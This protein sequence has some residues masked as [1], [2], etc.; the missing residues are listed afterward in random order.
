MQTAAEIGLIGLA[1][2]GE[3]LSLNLAN[4]GFAVSVFN[5][6]TAR[7]DAFIRGRARGT[8]ISGYPTLA[9]FI[10][11]LAPPRKIMLMLKAG[12]VV[13]EVIEQLLPY[14]EAGDILIDGG[15]SHYRDTKR[16]VVMLKGQGLHF[17]GCGVSGGEEGALHGP[18][19][20]PG[21]S[22]E[23]WPL[24]EPLL[25]PIAARLSDGSSCCSWLGPGG[26]GHFVKMVHNGI[27][28]GDMQ[29]IAE[30]YHLITELLGL[31]HRQIGEIFARWNSG[32]L[33]SYLI[34]ITAE[35]LSFQ[36]EDGSP[37]LEAILDAA[38]Q[39][40]TGKWTVDA[41]L[42]L[43]IPLSLISESVFA[44]CLSASKEQRL[45]AA[46]VFPGPGG[47]WSGDPRA[48]LRDLEAALYMAKLISYGQ[49]FQL[50]ATASRDFSWNL[51]LGEVARI[52]RGGCII[53]SAFL[54][55][56]SQAYAQCPE[57]DQLLL[58]PHF[59]TTLNQAQAALRRVITA[60]VTAGI[61]APCL[62]SSL[63]YFDGLR[64]SRLPANLIQA[65]RDYF[66]AHTYERTDQP[67]GRF[68]HTNWTGQGGET[69]SG[70]S[71]R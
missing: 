30:S 2:M 4:H 16:R 34:E 50:L 8:T 54:E 20:M 14:L 27:E 52:W 44:R 36:D 33:N 51:D 12:P 40:G 67:R 19:L 45:A 66:G 23:A 18:S 49:G 62:C 53:R 13:D 41:A 29:L 22:K 43:G 69:T 11:S 32:R 63:Q 68:F 9:A 47:S 39:K 28:Y 64:S 17:V 24:L 42:D 3:N 15:N 57:L 5:R 60:G 65:Q 58:A 71:K 7:T 48:L 61:P 26:A 6:T 70:S 21:G 55:T 31:E 46:P 56:I 37:L 59:S 10:R 38:A 1:V 25:L 35:I